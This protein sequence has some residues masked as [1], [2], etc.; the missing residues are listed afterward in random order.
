MGI[1]FSQ[2]RVHG[3]PSNE[4]VQLLICGRECICLRVG[5]KNWNIILI[6]CSIVLGT[7]Y[8]MWSG[9]DHDNIIMINHDDIDKVKWKDTGK[10]YNVEELK[11]ELQ[12]S[13]R[14]FEALLRQLDIQNHSVAYQARSIK[15]LKSSLRQGI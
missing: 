12:S 3:F 10:D 5:F 1:S 2:A 6:L 4:V 14:F 9:I 13:N 8:V 11:S 7:R 15:E